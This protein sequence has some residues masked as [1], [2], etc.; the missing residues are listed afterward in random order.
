MT[1]HSETIQK[2]RER[3]YVFS[4]AVPAC[5]RKISAGNCRNKRFRIPAFREDPKEKKSVFLDLFCPG[6]SCQVVESTRLS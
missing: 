3:P 6:D 5:F 4:S 1:H 2:G